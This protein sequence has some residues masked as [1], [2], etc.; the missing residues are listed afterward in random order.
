M[1]ITNK[2]R[3]DA[4]KIKYEE[5]LKET[6]LLMNAKE[7][8]ENK[9]IDKIRRLY[10]GPLY[11]E[12]GNNPEGVRK[13]RLEEQYNKLKREGCISNC[14]FKEFIKTCELKTYYADCSNDIKC[15]ERSWDKKT[16]KGNK[17]YNEYSSIYN[18]TS[19]LKDE[20]K[21][22]RNIID[23]YFWLRI[24]HNSL[25]YLNELAQIFLSSE[26][27]HQIINIRSKRPPH[28][29]RFIARQCFANREN[30]SFLKNT[31]VQYYLLH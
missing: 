28:T 22:L 11:A 29:P 5:K 13:D 2:S 26:R 27:F 17:S 24:A 6:K 8:E 19:D 14:S 10:L 23:A 20:V 3:D 12:C 21:Y 15:M 4:L 18:P 9:K 1:S 30:A 7:E 31:I 16:N 25:I